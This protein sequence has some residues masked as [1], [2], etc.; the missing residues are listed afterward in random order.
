MLLALALSLQPPEVSWIITAGDEFT[1]PLK[2]RCAT[3]LER[4]ISR[5]VN[6]EARDYTQ[7][8]METEACW[9]PNETFVAG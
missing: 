6:R 8:P 2:P 1:G 3:G 5:V 7:S 9:I 4:G